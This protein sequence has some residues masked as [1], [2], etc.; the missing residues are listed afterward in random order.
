MTWI[1]Y[2][3]YKEQLAQHAEVEQAAFTDKD[4]AGGGALA[5]G[6]LKQLPA[7]APGQEAQA[8]PPPPPPTAQP[9]PPTPPSPAT[10]QT[11]ATPQTPETPQAPTTQPTPQEMKP[12]EAVRAVSPTETPQPSDMKGVAPMPVE[13]VPLPTA[14]VGPDPNLPPAIERAEVKPDPSKDAPPTAEVQPMNT[15]NQFRALKFHQRKSHKL[16]FQ[17]LQT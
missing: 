11:I 3:E 2:D 5:Q 10:P 14:P 7:V 15:R 12:V 8:S 16:R 17:Q 9:S 13:T 1:G 4:V 6:E